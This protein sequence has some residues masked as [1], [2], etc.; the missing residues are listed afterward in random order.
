MR[1]ALPPSPTRFKRFTRPRGRTCIDLWGG[2]I[3]QRSDGGRHAR[4]RLRS[5]VDELGLPLLQPLQL[6]G[7]LPDIGGGDHDEMRLCLGRS[8]AEVEVSGH[9][10]VEVDLDRSCARPGPDKV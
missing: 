6:G 4:A 9:E 5:V 10:F 7:K 3:R 1:R 8:I 2:R